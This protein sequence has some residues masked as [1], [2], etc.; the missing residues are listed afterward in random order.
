MDPL[1][2]ILLIAGVAAFGGLMLWWH[3]SRSASLLDRWAERNGYRVLDREYRSFFKGPFF[4]TTSEGQT[5]YH[6]TVEDK[7][8]RRRTGWVRCGGWFLGLLSDNVEVR[9]DD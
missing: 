5:V 6:V 1:L 4:W 2:P 9:W 8:G 3:F 7:E